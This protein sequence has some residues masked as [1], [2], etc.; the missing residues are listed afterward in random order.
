MHRE[1]P[2]DNHAPEKSGREGPKGPG[3]SLKM[4]AL[5]VGFA[6]KRA[7]GSGFFRQGPTM[8]KKFAASL[9][10]RAGFEPMVVVSQPWNGSAGAMF[11]MA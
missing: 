7:D 5:G 1:R 4:A 11:A 2:L 6:R 9:A 10:D 3:S 8:E